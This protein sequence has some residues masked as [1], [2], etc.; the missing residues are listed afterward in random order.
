MSHDKLADV[1]Q[2][3]HELEQTNRRYKFGMAVLLPSLIVFLFCAARMPF[4]EGVMVQ[5]MTGRD[6]AGMWVDE[7]DVHHTVLE[8][9][10]A[11]G[12]VRYYTSL[13]PDGTVHSVYRDKNGVQRMELGVDR[14][15]TPFVFFKNE[16]GE[17][18]RSL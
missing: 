1:V 6:R 7:N 3:L 18:V 4:R 12:L 17:V 10:D 8:L 5:D 15:N 14:N 13:E 11:G 16:K 2:R 9:I